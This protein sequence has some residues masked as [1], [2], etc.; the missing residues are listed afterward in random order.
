M[1]TLDTQKKVK[2]NAEMNRINIKGSLPGKNAKKIIAMDTKYLVK[3]TKS[4]PVVGKRGKGLFVEDVDGNVF[5]DFAFLPGN[6]PLMFIR[7]IS[8]FFFTF[9]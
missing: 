4:L 3:S 9:F 2:K 6:D 7:F 5:L 8:A 1:I